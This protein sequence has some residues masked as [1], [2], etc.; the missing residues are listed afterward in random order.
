VADTTPSNKAERYGIWIKARGIQE[1]I[2]KK[3][4]MTDLMTEI[5]ALFFQLNYL[6]LNVL[7]FFG[8]FI[9]NQL[10]GSPVPGLNSVAKS[11]V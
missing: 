8:I 6:S 4:G 10:F 11:R 5:S 1:V 9:I 7:F 3:D 2:L